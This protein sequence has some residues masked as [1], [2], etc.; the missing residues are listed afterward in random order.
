[1]TVHLDI[2]CSENQPDALFVLNLFRQS[3]STFLHVS[4]AIP[5]VHA[6]IG[7]REIR[8]TQLDIC[9]YIVLS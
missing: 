2:L 8:Q 9:Y 7:I 6:L 4:G 3:T 1:M 5:V